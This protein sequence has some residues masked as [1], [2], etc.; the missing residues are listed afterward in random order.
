MKKLD[1]SKE[2]CFSLVQSLDL[3]SSQTAAFEQVIDSLRWR[4][5]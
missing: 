5:L 1:A 4:D 3:S 2:N